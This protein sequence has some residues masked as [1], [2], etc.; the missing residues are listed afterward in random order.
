[1]QIGVNDYVQG[2][3]AETFQK[4]LLYILDAVQAQLSDRT[5]VL[6]VTIPDYGKTPTGARY[7]QPAESEAGIKRFNAIVMSEAKTRGLPVADI[8]S[9]SQRVTDD[10][11]LIA[12]DGLQ[13]SGKQYTLWTDAIYGLVKPLLVPGTTSQN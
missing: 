12:L 6:L 11:S 9:I 3:K 1:M 5:K 7:G 10:T 13:P 2:V 8:F 4:N